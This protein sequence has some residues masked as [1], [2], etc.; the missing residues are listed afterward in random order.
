MNANR[1]TGLELI[2]QTRQSDPPPTI[3]LLQGDDH[4]FDLTRILGSLIKQVPPFELESLLADD[5]SSE[6]A[7]V[8]L[9][10]VTGDIALVGGLFSLFFC[11]YP[12]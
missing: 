7:A 10:S 8:D 12:L 5:I 4:G 6:K 2:E 9:K 11:M 3:I 1:K